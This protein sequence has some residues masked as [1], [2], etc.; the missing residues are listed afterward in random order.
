A[1][2]GKIDAAI[3]PNEANE[4]ADAELQMLKLLSPLS[5]EATVVRVY[6]DW[7]VQLPWNSR[8]KV[9]IDL[10]QAQEILDTDH[11]GLE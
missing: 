5:A 2:K 11:Y 6:I 1:V 10:R 8:I 4:I 9:K 7:M 3:C